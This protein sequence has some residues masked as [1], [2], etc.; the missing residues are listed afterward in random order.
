MAFNFPDSPTPGQQFFDPTSGARYTFSNGTWTQVASS[1]VLKGTTG[2]VPPGN[3]DPGQLWWESDTGRMFIFYVDPGGAPGQWVQISGPMRTG[4]FLDWPA[5]ASVDWWGPTEPAGTLFCAGQ[6]LLRASYAALFTAIGTTFGAADGTHFTLPDAR[7][8]VTAGKDNMN[9]TNAGR[10]AGV[11]GG[12]T[13][14]I[15]GGAGGAEGHTLIVSQMPSHVHTPT[16]SGSALYFNAGGGGY[17]MPVTTDGTATA[18]ST[19]SVGGDTVHNNTQPTII[20]NKLI[21][22][23]G[24]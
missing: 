13:G 17:R 12:V 11:A 23:G 2:D 6:S 9:G 18:L 21:C 14:T 15:L 24:V 5:G 4:G 8:R 1:P 7:G 20:C 10:L 3:P 19:T 22:T 16:Y